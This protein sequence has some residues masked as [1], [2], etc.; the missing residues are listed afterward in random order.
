M[1]QTYIRDEL[2]ALGRHGILSVEEQQIAAAT[3]IR[4]SFVDGAAAV[5]VPRSAGA[6]PRVSRDEG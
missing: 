2:S 1:L 4:A 5:A 3:S 6:A